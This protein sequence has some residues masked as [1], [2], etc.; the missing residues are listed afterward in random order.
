MRTLSLTVMLAAAAAA[1]AQEWTRF[2]GPN[3]TGI[4]PAR[5]APVKWTEKNFRWRVAI[6][7]IGHAQP[8]I[9]GDRIFLTSALN[10][11]MERLLLCLNKDDGKELWVKRYAL[12]THGKHRLNSFA[13][14]T[15]TVDKDRV[16]AVMASPEQ[17]LVKAWSHAGKELWSVD[18]GAF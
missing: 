2:R 13:S 5:G 18:L 6:P 10:N 17:F 9:W 8:V 4:S 16:Y 7:G 11:G 1:G 15:P 12:S 14:S 3:G